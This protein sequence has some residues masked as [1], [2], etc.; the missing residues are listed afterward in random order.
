M[1]PGPLSIGMASGEKEMSRL[2]RAASRARS[3]SAV[4]RGLATSIPEPMPATSRPPAMR[5][6]GMEMPKNPMINVPPMRK[7][8]RMMT[9]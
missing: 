6:P 4:L 5:R 7:L 2:A 3:S 8:T 1:E 9:M